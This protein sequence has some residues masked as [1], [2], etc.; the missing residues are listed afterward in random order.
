MNF[1][2]PVSF[3]LFFT[4][5]FAH[6]EVILSPGRM[7]P[8]ALP[9]RPVGDVFFPEGT[10]ISLSFEAGYAHDKELSL[11]PRLSF[12]IPWWSPFCAFTFSSELFE[13]YWT[14]EQLRKE[15][16][17]LEKKGLAKGDIRFGSRFL[18]FTL[19]EKSFHLYL[20]LE[21][22]TTTGKQRENARHTNS[23]QY[24]I[25]LSFKQRELKKH[26]LPHFFLF[27]E[28]ISGYLGFTAW[29]SGLAQQNDAFSWGLAFD[30]GK[31]EILNL[32]LEA[33]GYHGWQKNGDNPVL[34]SARFEK[35]LSSW[36]V[37]SEYQYGLQDFIAHSF[38]L[39]LKKI[40]AK[41]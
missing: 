29:Q 26:F 22:K 25:D 37:F 7:G 2:K 11:N 5:F 10:E 36:G 32:R 21:T 33:K 9:P 19:K 38:S 8:K 34:L 6:G 14:S 12:L 35:K 23:P 4:S 13:H 20:D 30:Y 18:L 39:G 31:D 16:G 1:I 40:F 15:R 17:A 27:P 3:L 28:S 41:S 24:E